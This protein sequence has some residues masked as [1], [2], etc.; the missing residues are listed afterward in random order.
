KI[1]KPKTKHIGLVSAILGFIWLVAVFI[2]SYVMINLNLEKEKIESLFEENFET[3]ISKSDIILNNNDT[4]NVIFQRD[5]RIFTINDTISGT[6]K[7]SE[8]DDIDVEILESTTGNAFIEIEEKI[9]NDKKITFT[10]YGL[11]K[12]NVK[13]EQSK[14]SNTLNYNYSIKSDTLVLSNAILTTLNDF[15]E[16]SKVRIKLY[17]TENQYIKINSNDN[18]YFWN[19]QI[20]EGKHYYKFN[21]A[22]ILQNTNNTIN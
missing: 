19:Q 9:F 21:N 5:P 17:I 1:L 7:Y 15:T 11:T 4:L 20:D 22:G 10:G 16:D 6:L 8:V 13:I 2:F 12:H 18:R 14:N 3:K